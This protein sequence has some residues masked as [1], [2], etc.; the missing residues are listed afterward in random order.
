MPHGCVPQADPHQARHAPRTFPPPRTQ[1][2]QAHS[3]H[4]TTQHTL[5]PPH[6][7]RRVRTR[8][9]SATP[10]PRC[11]PDSLKGGTRRTRGEER[12]H[13]PSPTV[14]PR[15]TSTNSRLQSSATT[16]TTHPT[17]PLLCL[18]R[19]RRAQG[20][21]PTTTLALLLHC[22]PRPL[23]IPPHDDPSCRPLLSLYA[24]CAD[25]P[26]HNTVRRVE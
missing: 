15:R 7:R 21:P 9:R 19:S 22:S 12:N 3:R 5:L 10:P 2:R 24:S 23:A 18:S 8:Q 13:T 14:P 4:A 17:S 11:R 20:H 1:A 16:T 26:R 25:P 6:E